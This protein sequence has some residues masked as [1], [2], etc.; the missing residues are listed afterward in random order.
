LQYAISTFT[1]PTIWKFQELQVQT[2]GKLQPLQILTIVNPNS[3]NFNNLQEARDIN[4]N[5]NDFKNDS[6]KFQK[7]DNCNSTPCKGHWW[8][9]FHRM[10][11]NFAIEEFNQKKYK[12]ETK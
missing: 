6:T 12:K 5:Q 3:P 4:C 9:A 1:I 10:Q 8:N 2:I 7:E 11:P